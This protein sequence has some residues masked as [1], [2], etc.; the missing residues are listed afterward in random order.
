MSLRMHLTIT[1]GSVGDSDCS[2]Y[3]GQGMSA[4]SGSSCEDN[5]LSDTFRTSLNSLMLLQSDRDV[6]ANAGT[7]KGFTNTSHT[8]TH[9]P[10]K[11]Y[12][13]HLQ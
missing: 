13:M 10:L 11:S 8:L 12:K 7:A 4:P 9:T 1:F 5:F 6:S 3:G 2:W